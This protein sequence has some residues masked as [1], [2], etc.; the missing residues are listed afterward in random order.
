MNL[1]SND[2]VAL[3]IGVCRHLSN[4]TPCYYLAAKG[5]TIYFWQLPEEGEQGEKIFGGCEME[6]R[7]SRRLMYLLIYL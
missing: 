6:S 1:E 7:V 5:H 4:A 3:S 2:V